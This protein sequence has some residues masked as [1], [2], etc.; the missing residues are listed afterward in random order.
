MAQLIRCL[1]ITLGGDAARHR[2]VSLLVPAIAAIVALAAACSGDGQG[3]ADAD[4]ETR[5]L[6]VSTS[7]I[8]ADWVSNVGGERVDSV[9]LVP[10]GAS[11]HGY[12]PGARAV[13]RVADADLVF[14]IGLGL[15]SK[16]VIDLVKGVTGDDV[17]V[18]ELG[19]VADPLPIGGA[20]QEDAEPDGD[21]AEDGTMDPHFWLDPLRVV[22]AVREISARLTA[23][24][25]AGADAYLANADAFASELQELHEWIAGRVATLSGDRRKLVTSHDTLGYFATRYGFTIVGSAIPGV[26]TA[27][28]TTPRELADLIEAVRAQG[29]PAVFAETIENRRLVEQ[30]ARETGVTVVASLYTGS[31]GG[32]GSGAETYLEMMRA[33]VDIIV[34]ALGDTNR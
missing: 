28:E 15:E 21:R 5:L 1:N 22:A 31:L 25:P 20:A 13:S 17:A 2:R 3:P 9:S 14:A 8:V 24:D 34:E 30:L 19:P 18:V 7:N 4:G 6:V 16:Q 26:T 33:N 23:I 32:P 11:P 29:V 10:I 27:R 12:M